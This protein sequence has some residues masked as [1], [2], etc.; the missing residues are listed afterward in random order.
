MKFTRQ[1]KAILQEVQNRHDHPSAD[2]IYNSL[3]S[4]LPHLSLGTVYRNLEQLYQNGYI[5]KVFC[6]AQP[7]RFDGDTSHHTHFV[8]TGCN[9]IE[10]LKI[11][12]DIIQSIFS[13]NDLDGK[14]IETISITVYGLCNSC[15]QL[16]KG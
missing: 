14:K 15:S 8:C 9:K 11:S 10:D 3:R 16:D 5:R 4:N 6:D 7:Q 2:D 1:R 13:V 12:S